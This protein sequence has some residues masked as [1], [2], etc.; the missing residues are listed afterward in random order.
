VPMAG[1]CLAWLICVP[2]GEAGA[3]PGGGVNPNRLILRLSDLALGYLNV[4]LQEEQGD[5]IYCSRLTHPE[6]TPAEMGR[7]ID[8]FHPRGCLGAY[9]R[10]YSPPGEAAGP[11]V[12]GTGALPLRSDRAANAGW[13]VLPEILG[14][15]YSNQQ[16][17]EVEASVH[18]GKATRLFH[19]YQAKTRKEA[20]KVTFLAWRSGNSIEAVMAAGQSFSSADRAAVRLAALQQKHVRDP[21]RYTLAERFD[22]EVPLD[23]PAVDLPVYWLGR[24]FRPG[25]NLP[26]NRLFDAGFPGR[27]IA[28]SAD[29]F[30]EGPTAPLYIRYANIR[31]GT[32]TPETW[33]VFAGSKTGRAITTWK[34]TQTR[35]IPLAGGTATIFGGYRTNTQRCPAQAPRAFTAW[36]DIG[37]V[38]VVVNPPFAADSIEVVNPYG[39]FGGM[40][41]IVRSLV[42]R[43]KRFP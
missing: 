21:T 8:R 42:L 22:G 24:N 30:E 33:S 9:R 23:D 6:D 19:R 11:L 35:V 43:P 39:S 5:R 34:C 25:G 15:L 16:P 2:R 13:R 41:A 29:P 20:R 17:Q 14:R 10:L 38:K 18:V 4:D 40:E 3:Q 12:V 37:G 36:V 32:W 26:D 1:L 27:A 31:L 7:F 28:E